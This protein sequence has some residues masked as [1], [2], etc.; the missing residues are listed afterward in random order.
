MFT[1][2]YEVPLDQ[3]ESVVKIS[4]VEKM[5]HERYQKMAMFG[6]NVVGDSAESVKMISITAG[7][8]YIFENLNPYS[9]TLAG[10]IK[11]LETR[12][13][14]IGIEVIEKVRRFIACSQRACLVVEFNR[15]DG[16]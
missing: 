7:K 9:R 1:V 5:K 12:D 6:G 2:S 8:K 4:F 15:V 11:S 14:L 13:T 10:T 3:N 16:E